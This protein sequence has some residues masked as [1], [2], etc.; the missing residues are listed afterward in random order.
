MFNLLGRRERDRADFSGEN[1]LNCL[2]ERPAILRQRP[3]IDRH[4][5]D[6]GASLGETVKQL[7][8]RL[9]ILLDG[10]PQAGDRNACVDQCEGFPPGVRLRDLE[11]DDSA[12][13]DRTADAG[14]GPRAITTTR[15][16]SWGQ[17]SSGNRV[18]VASTK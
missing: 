9:S 7:L 15:A 18:S 2:T 14:L 8:V 6:E 13:S 17:S 12:L 11:V 16:S 5:R 1:L 3:A 4:A 10:E